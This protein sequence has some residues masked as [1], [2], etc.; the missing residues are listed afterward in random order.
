[1]SPFVQLCLLRFT[2]P[3][4][5]S[6]LYALECI[7]NN[8]PGG[9]QSI[10]LFGQGAVPAVRAICVGSEGNDGSELFTTKPYLNSLQ[11]LPILLVL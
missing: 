11:N 10:E 8:D 9:M 5:G 4:A 1:M 6:Y 3:D 2:P 7:L